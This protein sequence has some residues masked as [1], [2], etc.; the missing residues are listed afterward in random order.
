MVIRTPADLGSLIRD[1]RRE[2][3]WNQQALADRAGV[4][5]QWLV[6]V[7]RGKPRAAVELILR[8]L[9]ALEVVLTVQPR[10]S[11]PK[12]RPVPLADIDAIVRQARGRL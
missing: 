2:L 10:S 11:R 4:G 8:T 5:R 12:G 1:R 6:E 9:D 3:G 7:E